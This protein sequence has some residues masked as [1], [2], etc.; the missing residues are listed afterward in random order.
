MKCDNCPCSCTIQ[1]PEGYLDWE[2]LA[3]R[4]DDMYKSEDG[5]HIKKAVAEQIAKDAEDSHMRF[6]I[7]FVEWMENQTDKEEVK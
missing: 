4:E 7:G 1:E 5:C 3:G 6:I 2:C